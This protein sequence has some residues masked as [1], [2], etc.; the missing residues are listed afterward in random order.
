MLREETRGLEF[1]RCA[2]GVADGTSNEAS[3][4]SLAP[5]RIEKVATGG[6]EGDSRERVVR[7]VDMKGA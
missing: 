4:R 5:S 7:R 1:E 6:S 3:E 2:E